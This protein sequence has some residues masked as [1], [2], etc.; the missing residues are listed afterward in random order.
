M[1]R[2]LVSNDSTK[3]NTPKFSKFN[4]VKE[5]VKPPAL[6]E[7]NVNKFYESF[8]AEYP[9]TYL[10]KSSTYLYSEGILPYVVMIGS[11][12]TVRLSKKMMIVLK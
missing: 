9:D 5:S 6:N 7:F 3:T 12:L 2:Y 1:N 10:S 8:L 11:D 4:V